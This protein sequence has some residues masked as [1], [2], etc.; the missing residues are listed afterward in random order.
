VSASA[1]NQF[2]E[3]YCGDTHELDVPMLDKVVVGS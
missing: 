3:G 1:V 2:E